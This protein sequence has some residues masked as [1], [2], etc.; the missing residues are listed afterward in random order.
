M[1]YDQGTGVAPDP[2]KVVELLAKA[3]DAGDALGCRILGK[4]YLAGTTVKADA[5]RGR[6]LR[7]RACKLGDAESCSPR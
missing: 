2:G 5:A 7:A 1:M 3:C 4:F 6:E